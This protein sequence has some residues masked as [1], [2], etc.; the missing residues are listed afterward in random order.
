MV[1]EAMS[2]L[3]LPP[4][5]PSI[6][7]VAAAPAP[8]PSGDPLAPPAPSLSEREVRRESSM[9]LATLVFSASESLK[10]ASGFLEV[11][12]YLLCMSKNNNLDPSL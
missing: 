3:P 11:I 5:P 8:P 1:S 9:R 6:A 12:T 2:L 10:R 7:E 4:S